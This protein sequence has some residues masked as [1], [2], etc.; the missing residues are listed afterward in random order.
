ME[1]AGHPRTSSDGGQL[2]P[3]P[4]SEVPPTIFKAN[5]GTNETAELQ[6]LLDKLNLA[7][8]PIANSQN[9]KGDALDHLYAWARTSQEYKA[10]VDWSARSSCCVLW[11]DGIP[12]AGKTE[13]LQAAV[14]EL[15][16]QGKG[17]SDQS[18]SSNKVASFF[19]DSCG[20]QP[21]N[22]LSAAKVLIFNVLSQQPWLRKHLSSKFITTRRA[23]F[24]NPSDFYA[25]STLLY[26]MIE[27]D[28][29]TET[30]FVIDGLEEFVIDKALDVSGRRHHVGGGGLKNLVDKEPLDEMLGMIFTTIQ[31][32]NKVKWLLSIDSKRCDAKLGLLKDGEQLRLTLDPRLEAIKDVA[33]KFAASPVVE[34]ANAAGYRGNIRETVTNQ[35]QGL[36][37]GD[38]LWL[39][40]ALD[41]L[42]ASPTTWNA[43]EIL[44]KLQEKT[45]DVPS[46]YRSR[47]DTIR[48]LAPR[49]QKYCKDTLEAVAVAYQPLLLS[50]LVDLIDLPEEVDPT[51][52]VGSWLYIFLE[53]REGCLCYKHLSARDFIRRDMGKQGIL[54]KHA[55]MTRSC[56]KLLP[57]R[58]D[59]SQ[60]VSREESVGKPAGISAHYANLF[61]IKHL[62]ELGG[63]DQESLRDHLI[64]W[65]E[66][67]DPKG[68]FPEALSMMAKLSAA[69][70]ATVCFPFLIF[71]SF[72]AN[73]P[74]L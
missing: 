36:P 26:S 41:I 25:L 15:S 57:K 68:L 8:Q 18:S 33:H 39:N 37:S 73:R 54:K 13:L 30:Y 48:S 72:L 62:S 14:R 46:L 49:D 7:K 5:D 16:E 51:V 61:W 9:H 65:L 60:L 1:V 27:D 52:V 71:F 69:L 12:A 23:G 4:L 17:V 45:P 31:L 64:Q 21:G 50:E 74:D 53:I 38:L 19:C 70:R 6:Q 56:L 34:I 67:L 24:D 28:K 66:L 55:D 10:F 22:A 63:S 44:N 32:S 11:V 29:F 42:K 3:S 35:L 58:F 59:G 20:F 40:T 43:P 47:M 2:S